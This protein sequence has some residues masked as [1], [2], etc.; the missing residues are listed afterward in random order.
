MVTIFES[1]AVRAYEVL[2]IE[3]LTNTPL[4]AWRMLRRLSH[5]ARIHKKNLAR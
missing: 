5:Q 2:V 3:K 1:I 4:G